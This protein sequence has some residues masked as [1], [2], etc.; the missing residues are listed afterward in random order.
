MANGLNATCTRH[1]A[2]AASTVQVGSDNK[3]SYRSFIIDLYG[4]LLHSGKPVPGAAMLHY[5]NPVPGAA[6]MMADLQKK[7][8]PFVILTNEDRE[9]TTV[10]VDSLQKKFPGVQLDTR[11]IFTASDSVRLF[12]L[13]KF[14][15]GWQGS[16]YIIGEY[17]LLNNLREVFVNHAKSGSFVLTMDEDFPSNMKKVDYVVVGAVYS[18]SK[19][20]L[21]YGQSLE[22]ACVF[23]EAGAKVLSA[24]S[25]YLEMNDH[26]EFKFGQPGLTVET[27]QAITG[28]SSYTLGKP[29][30][31]MLRSAWRQMALHYGIGL[32]FSD[33]LYVG[34]SLDT[35][36]RTALEHDIDCALLAGDERAKAELACS[37]LAPTFVF[38][39][40]AD[41]HQ[42]FLK[43]D[44]GGYRSSRVQELPEAPVA[45]AAEDTST[46]ET[47]DKEADGT[48][49]CFIFDMDGVIQRFGVPIPGAEQMLCELQKQQIPLLL[50]TNED[51]YTNAGLL[52]NLHR[53]LG[54]V[55]LDPGHL[56]TAANSMRMFFESKFARGWKGSVYVI[57]EEGLLHDIRSA[58][59]RFGSEGSV[60]LTL[61]DPSPLTHVDFVVVGSVYSTSARGAAF[62]KSLERACAFVRAGAKVLCSC[63]DDFEV[64]ET[65]EVK[66]GSP[67]PTVRALQRSTGNSFYSLGKPNP[68]MLRAAWRQMIEYHHSVPG[69]KFSNAL[70][71]GDSLGTDIQ[72]ALEHDIDCALVLSGT[73]TRE[74]LDRSPLVPTFVFDDIADL[75]AAFVAGN[76]RR[77]PTGLTS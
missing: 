44:L 27:L 21:A 57:G 69:L 8:V 76:L 14:A 26:G 11:H 3:K 10:L 51:R 74:K 47:G 52:A 64:T 40:I 31:K 34:N 77:R 59:S 61:D 38:E 22:R 6:L 37:P 16:I 18:T 65:G 29:N 49:E 42:A 2:H 4:A 75:H 56:F 41:V 71:I 1:F 67:G 33:V 70:F 17:G 12:F 48:Y 39:S 62:V 43:G 5:G 23:I 13:Q 72:T 7:A 55:R 24:Q 73:T 19:A 58:F 54:D 68:H 50:L 30:P 25:E 15:A 45:M 28:S 66:L 46:L 53:M 60:V 35:D 63:P 20:G 32:D 9:D 36:I